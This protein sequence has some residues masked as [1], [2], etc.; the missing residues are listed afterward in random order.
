M[1]I[2][3]RAKEHLERAM[4]VGGYFGCCLTLGGSSSI[5]AGDGISPGSDVEE[6]KS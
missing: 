1:T 5:C 2:G 4:L 3:G 6:L